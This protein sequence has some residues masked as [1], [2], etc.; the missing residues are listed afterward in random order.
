MKKFLFFSFFLI[1]TCGCIAQITVKKNPIKTVVSINSCGSLSRGGDELITDKG[2]YLIRLYTSNKF[3]NPILVHLKSREE[4][5]I[6]L[7]DIM[8]K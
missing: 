5:L 6:T 4:A 7:K 2:Y 3:D 8:D 1:F